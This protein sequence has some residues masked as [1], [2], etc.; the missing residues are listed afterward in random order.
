[1]V[2][3]ESPKKLAVAPPGGRGGR[4]GAEGRGRLEVRRRGQPGLRPGGG[5]DLAVGP[6]KFTF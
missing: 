1:M 2:S 6:Q 4:A 3:E 5:A